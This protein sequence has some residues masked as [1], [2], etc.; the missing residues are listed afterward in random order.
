MTQ[1]RAGAGV[2]DNFSTATPGNVLPSNDSRNAPPA[3]ET[4]VNRS[5]TEATL[6]A[7]TVSPP[8]A[9]LTSLPAAVSSAAASATSTVPLS[10]GSY[11][12]APNG[13]FQT[14]VLARARTEM[15][16]SIVRGPMS[17]IMSVAPTSSTETTRQGACAASLC[18]TT[19]ST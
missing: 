12:K 5:V 3:V 2:G 7:A 19:T 16:Y 11:S 8:P 18:A 6:S 10:N 9:K 14:K 1:L 4:W 15:T 17:R 13:P